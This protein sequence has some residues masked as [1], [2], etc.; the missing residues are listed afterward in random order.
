VSAAGSA[1]ASAAP[2][3]TGQ[4]RAA[5]SDT[6]G[7]KTAIGGSDPS[8]VLVDAD[9]FSTALDKGKWGVYESTAANGSSWSASAVRTTGGEL[10]ITGTGTNPTG[11]GNVAGGLCWCGTNGNR[12]YGIWQ[13]RARFDAGA[14]YG[15]IVGL[16]P[17]S[18]N[19]DAEGYISAVN[20]PA[21][22]RR[23]LTGRLVWPDGGADTGPATGNF[24]VWHTYTI[25]W[26]AGF[27]KLSIDGK[28]Y[29]DSTKSTAKPVI[30]HTPLHLYMQLVIGPKNGVPPAD[31][32][33]PA[34]V[35]MHV[36]WVRFY[37]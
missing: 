36:D 9:D 15:P 1:P 22:D 16:W 7:A 11:A 26:R 20:A 25:E 4:P 37:R 5:R 23:S 18:D 13:V 19:G 21:A 31:A 2:A 28:A 35:V 29:Y 12:L 30:P 33:T 32:S 8:R 34:H 14:G 17:Q 24:T 3:A 6:T 10:Q 27:V